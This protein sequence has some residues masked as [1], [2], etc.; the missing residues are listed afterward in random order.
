MKFIS[1]PKYFVYKRKQLVIIAWLAALYQPNTV[2][3]YE[4]VHKRVK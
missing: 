1:N 2:L 4:K 3:L